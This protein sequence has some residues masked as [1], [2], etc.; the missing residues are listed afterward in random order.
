MCFS[1]QF[2]FSQKVFEV[3]PTLWVGLPGLS[4]DTQTVQE[5]LKFRTQVRKRRKSIDWGRTIC[6]FPL[7]DLFSTS[8]LLF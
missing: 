3:Q 5:K 1:F 8:T 7:V 6:F 2:F 4:T